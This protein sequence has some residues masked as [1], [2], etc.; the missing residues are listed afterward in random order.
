MSTPGTQPAWALSAVP[1]PPLMVTTREEVALPE[2]VAGDQGSGVPVVMEGQSPAADTYPRT[3]V[4]GGCRP[5]FWVS[6]ERTVK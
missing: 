1:T 3:V 2:M 6:Y 4:A 5:S